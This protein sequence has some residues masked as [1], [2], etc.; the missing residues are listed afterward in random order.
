MSSRA[1]LFDISTYQETSQIPGD[2]DYDLLASRVDGG[3][4]RM[5][6][7]KDFDSDFKRFYANLKDKTILSSYTWGR[8]KEYAKP[9]AEIVCAALK[10]YPT[11]FRH[12]LDF[13]KYPGDPILPSN[14]NIVQWCLDWGD[15]Y[16][17]HF[18]EWPLLYING[19]ISLRILASRHP[20]LS[21][22]FEWPLWFT[23]PGAEA[24]IYSKGYL[25]G[26]KEWTFWQYSWAGDNHSF[27][28]MEYYGVESHGIDLNYFKGDVADF[29]KWAGIDQEP[30]PT[31]TPE[32]N[33]S[34]ELVALRTAADAIERKVMFK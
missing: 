3:F 33:I 24:V 26:W 27:N 25:G 2:I 9:Q 11:E 10:D 22:L 30:I 1:K 28:G 23:Y 8:W 16:R 14:Y 12:A 18:N 7:G 4:I 31:P 21:E 19:D 34:G 17:A 5:M 6:S 20:R 32:I 15:V 13:E 29:K